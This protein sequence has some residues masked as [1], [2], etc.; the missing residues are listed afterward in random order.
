MKKLLVLALTVI[1]VLSIGVIVLADSTTPATTFHGEIDGVWDS[2][3]TTTTTGG[4]FTVDSAIS[5]NIS[6]ETEFTWGGLEKGYGSAGVDGANPSANAIGNMDHYFVSVDTGY[7]VLKTGWV[8]NWTGQDMDQL[9][10]LLWDQG[11]HVGT[12][13]IYSYKIIDPLSFSVGYEYQTGDSGLLVDYTGANYG[14]EFAYAQPGSV[15]AGS[16][17]LDG[18]VNTDA[19]YGFNAYYKPFDGVQVWGQYA[20]KSSANMDSTED[21]NFY[22]GAK[23]NK[24]TG[25]WGEAEYE[26]LGSNNDMDLEAGYYIQPGANLFVRDRDTKGVSTTYAILAISF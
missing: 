18:S 26:T 1:L 7:G 6:F 11:K 22:I 20:I 21:G 3:H 17:L 10:D 24:G 4:G 5:K 25:L 8:D 14:V 16:N 19:S 23:Y 9:G 15:K 12:N 13:L 2:T